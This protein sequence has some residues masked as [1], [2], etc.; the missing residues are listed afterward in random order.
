MTFQQSTPELLAELFNEERCRRDIAKLS[1]GPRDRWIILDDGPLAGCRFPVDPYAAVD[2]SCGVTQQTPRGVMSV[3]YRKL[4]S[5]QWRF[6]GLR[7]VGW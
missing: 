3:L 7:A 4:P 5:G 2:A 1:A 6:D